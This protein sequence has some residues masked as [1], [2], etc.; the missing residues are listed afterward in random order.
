MVLSQ[1]LYELLVAVVQLYEA[2]K[3]PVTSTEIAER[4]GKS[5]GTVRNSMSALKA[6]GLIEARTGPNGGY[7]PTVKGLE[8]VK[9]PQALERLWEPLQVVV[10]D[11][12][13]R[14]YALELDLIGLTDPAGVKATLR[15]TGS[16]HQLREGVRIRVGPTP[17]TRLMIAGIV[18]G[19]DFKRKEVLLSVETFV[20]VPRITASEVMTPNPIVVREDEA[21]SSVAR[22]LLK[23]DIRA[24]PV[25][26]SQER[27]C[28]IIGASRIVRAYLD[29]NHDARVRDYMEK[30]VPVIRPDTDILDIMKILASRKTGRAV[31]VDEEG[32][33]KGIVTRTD[34]LNKLVSLTTLE[35]RS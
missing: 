27:L 14:I 24:L 21:L 13:S 6:L 23:N 2:N 7:V 10:D 26:D 12:P 35:P 17:R 29:G 9:A 1:S 15:V 19:V 4:L 11:H 28:G 18:S 22:L 3:R 25:V 31:V 20:A 16:I 32:K 33:P 34:V 30:N 5:D 8:C